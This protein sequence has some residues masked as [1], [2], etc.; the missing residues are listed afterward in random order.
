MLCSFVFDGVDS[1][2][3]GIAVVYF[4]SLESSYS[5][6]D[7]TE[8]KLETYGNGNKWSIVSQKYSEPISFKM[9]IINKDGSEIT[10]EKERA[11]K[12]WLCR[13]GTFHWLQFTMEDECICYRANFSNPQLLPVGKVVGME[14][15]VTTDSPHGYSS[16]IKKRFS[17]PAKNGNTNIFVNSDDY[18]YIYPLMKITVL[19][20]GTLT[21]TNDNESDTH[22]NF[23]LSNCIANE[24]ITIDSAIPCLESSVSSHDVFTDSNKRFPRLKQGKNKLTFSLPC[25]VEMEYRESRKV[26]VF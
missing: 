11:L 8:L 12:K 17:F 23:Y 3:Y 21:L 24:T 19:S 14:F 15:T 20:S 2:S 22:N 7:Q 1:A 4:G 16:T 25:K 26:G 6:G 13:Q 18:D 5:A 9:Q 10:R